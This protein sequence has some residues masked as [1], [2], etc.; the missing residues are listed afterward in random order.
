[1]DAGAVNAIQ[2][3]WQAVV[4]RRAANAATPKKKEGS[5]PSFS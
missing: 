1:M 3:F 5:A 4:L 2:G